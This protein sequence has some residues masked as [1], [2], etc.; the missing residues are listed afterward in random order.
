[1]IPLIIILSVIPYAF[2]GFFAGGLWKKVL[3]AKW[4][5][6]DSYWVNKSYSYSKYLVNPDDD[7][8][9]SKVDGCREESCTNAGIWLGIVWPISLILVGTLYLLYHSSIKL[10]AGL[11][12]AGRKGM[13]TG[14]RL[15]HKE[16]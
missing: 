15:L 2:V 6:K 9:Y 12:A 10:A 7:G 14:D 5:H 16:N 8:T 4:N 11:Q 3:H 13:S 1:M